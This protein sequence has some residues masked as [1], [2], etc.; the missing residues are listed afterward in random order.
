MAK[1]KNLSKEDLEDVSTYE[2][3]SSK[4]NTPTYNPN[5]VRLNDIQIKVKCLNE[6]QKK[7]RRAI[8]NKD[9]VISTGHPGTGKT[10]ISLLTALHL[11]KT[12]PKYKRLVLIKSLQVIKGEDLGYLPGS[13]AEKIEPY[14]LSFIGNLDKI[15]GNPN[16]TSALI[17]KGVLELFPIAYIRGVTIDNAIVIIDEAQNLDIHTFKSIITRIGNN[18]K[19][20]FLGDT[21]QIDRRIKSESCLKS[22]SKL[23]ED[24]EY[25]DSVIFT[26]EESIRNPIIP[27]LL[28]LLKDEE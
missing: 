9:V 14:M 17:D 25:A 24:V 28:D 7:L 26:D 8:E 16:I 20:I 12:K 15:I 22:I 3:L 10:Y 13:V 11:L 21:E 5:K 4:R 19:M 27:K 23:F 6:K 1:R 18:C 2:E